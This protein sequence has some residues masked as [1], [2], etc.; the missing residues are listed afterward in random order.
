MR[1]FSRMHIVGLGHTKTSFLEPV[2]NENRTLRCD[3][4]NI[5]A[6][7][8]YIL[9]YDSKYLLP[10]QGCLGLGVLDRPVSLLLFT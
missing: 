5:S 8:A 4:E 10:E 6:R 3:E 7:N 1:P 9:H 2:P